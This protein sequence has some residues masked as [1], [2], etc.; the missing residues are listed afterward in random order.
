[1]EKF[2]NKNKQ[3]GSLIISEKEFWNLRDLLD[4]LLFP[5][6]G[7]ETINGNTY[8]TPL[9]FESGR[10][11]SLMSMAHTN[12]L[13]YSWVVKNFNI[14]TYD[15]LYKF[16]QENYKDLYSP[17]GTYFHQIYSIIENTMKV[18][19]KNEELAAKEF[20]K[21]FAEKGYNIK[22]KV[23]E[24]YSSDDLINGY[25]LTFMWSGR[26]I[27]CQVKPLVSSDIQGDNYIIQSKGLMKLYPKVNYLLFADAKSGNCLI[28]RNKN[29]TINGLYVTIPSS[30]KI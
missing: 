6:Y 25:D 9:P 13:S 17:T 8:L 4:S 14:K 22:I 20:E 28:F 7:T 1:M 15:E 10:M 12:V 3:L 5:L 16:I 27:G 30:E 19:K 24:D 11:A 2:S 29:V 23:C 26:E 18:G 21:K